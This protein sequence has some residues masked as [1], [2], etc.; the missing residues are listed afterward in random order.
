MT[1]RSTMLAAALALTLAAVPAMAA[2]VVDCPLRESPFSIDSPLIDVL[3]SPAAT[4]V[5]RRL[6]PD[7]FTRL[8]A[9]FAGTTAPSFAAIVSLRNA[10]GLGGIEPDKLTALDRELRAIPVTEDDKRARCARYDN[11]VPRFNMPVG[12][13]RLLLFEKI[14]GFEDTPS[15]EAAHAAFLEMAGRQGWAIVS[16]TSGG[17]MNPAILRQFDAVIWNNVSGDVLTL[18]QRSAFKNWI[19]KGGAFIGIHGSAGDPVTFWDWYAD[20]LIG[21][22]FL[23]H[24]MAP[25]FQQARIA[26]EPHHP[27]STAVPAEWVMNDEWYSFRTNPRSSGA[28]VLATLDERTYSPVG[29]S[30]VDLRMGDHPIAWTKCIGKGRMF[31]SAIGHRPETYSAPNYVHMLEAAVAWAADR[32]KQGSCKR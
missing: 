9:S 32:R 6:G 16:T 17:A 31:Y 28:Q 27:L 29:H 19:E 30:K 18:A 10:S 1:R 15:V 21:A 13:P 12:K 23:A 22:R 7:R 20:T 25:Q 14:N 2:P 3:L 24:P 26:T 8:P 11:D 4:D 5:V